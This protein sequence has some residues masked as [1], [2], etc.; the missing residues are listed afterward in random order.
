MPALENAVR[1]GLIALAL[2]FGF[3]ATMSL[4]AAVALATPGGPL[5]FIWRINPAGHDGLRMLGVV[6]VPLMLLVSAGCA[7]TAYG[8]WNKRPW[9]RYLAIIILTINVIGDV[10]N[11]AIRHDWR[12]LIGVSI[13]GALIWYLIRQR[14]EFIG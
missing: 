1:K 3:G 4:L 2:F 5:E 11:A 13:G 9:G 7:A 10:S 6:A 12:T 14:L 8:L